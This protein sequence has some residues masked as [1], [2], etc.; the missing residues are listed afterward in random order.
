MADGRLRFRDC[1]YVLLLGA[2]VAALAWAWQFESPPPDLAD[3]LAA[4]AGLRP[5]KEPF[6]LLWHYIAAPIC[7]EFGLQTAGTVLRIAGHVSLGA[8]AILVTALFRMMLP[9][10]MRRGEHIASWWRVVVRFVLFQGVALF[11][12][13]EPVWNAFRWFSPQSLQVLIAVLAAICYV[14]HLKTERRAPLF[15]AYALLGV[16]SADTPAGAVLIVFASVGL[17]LRRHMRNAGLVATLEENP[18]AAALMSWRLTLAFAVG[19]VAG[20]VLEIRAFDSLDGLAAFGWTQDNRAY[21]LPIAYLKAFLSMCSPAGIAISV[22]VVLLPVI[23]EFLLIRLATDDEKHLAYLH[24]VMFLGAGLVAFS[25]LTGA[26]SLWFW[27]WGGEEGCLTDGLLKCFAMCLC[28][29]SVFWALGVFT[30]ELYLRNFRRIETLRFQDAAETKGA[31]DALAPMTRMQRIV[32][33]CL[34]VEPVLALACVLPFRAQGMERVMLGIVADAAKETVEECNG[35]EYLFTDG[36]IDAIVELAAASAGSRLRTLSMMGGAED[37]R[38]TYLRTRGVKDSE[39]LALL[40]SGAADALRTWVRSRPD[41]TGTYAVQ[42][43]FELWRR[44][45][46]PMPECS[47][48]VARPDGF[49]PGEAERG[50]T[51]GRALSERILALYGDGDPGE[52][53]DRA[54]RDAFLFVQW[55][56]SVLARHRANA[57]DGRGA[58]ALAMEETR[59]ADALDK[60]NGALD[61][62]RMTMAWAGRRKLERMTPQEGLRLGLARADFALARTFAL[63]VLDIS[64]DD[65]SANFALGMDFFVQKQ[66]SRAQAYLERCLERRPDDP[67]VLNNLAQCHLRQGDPAGALPYAEHAQ[68]IFPDSPEIK[69]T[70]ERIRAALKKSETA[71]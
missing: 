62:I 44:D 17:V 57:Y 47:G 54:L 29:I 71:R 7:R 38:E 55:R 15:V 1:L 35:V 46:K 66:Y 22:A 20:A 67:A 34:L 41:K 70:M 52:T 27:T 10:T 13:S 36:G 28:A 60:K 59:I 3:S 45:E 4:A 24:G 14:A 2:A 32:R 8:L 42:I 9:A 33:A 18:F 50:A 30:T 53:P 26:E 31:V 49:P 65:P 19:A 56:L 63:R 61:R 37:A 21:E 64:P 11:C 68:E 48:L 51:A 6:S 40:K 25:Q 58:T 23:V 69:R 16:L 39:D 5:P 43:G 12:C